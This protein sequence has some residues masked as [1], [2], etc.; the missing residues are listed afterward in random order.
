MTKKIVYISIIIA[1]IILG[2]FAAVK[3]SEDNKTTQVTTDTLN[4]TNKTLEENLAEENNIVE[5][6]NEITE[7]NNVEKDETTNNQQTPEEKAKQIVKENWGEDDLVYYSY[8]GKDE[9]GRY[10]IC[11]R[12][13]STTKEL[14][15]Y[16]VDVE[17]GSFDIE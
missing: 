5:S 12:E 13:K 10:V 17:T 11:V 16:Y 7:N 14:Y 4:Y 9:N 1:L 2:I 3:M 6:K 8:D 15:R